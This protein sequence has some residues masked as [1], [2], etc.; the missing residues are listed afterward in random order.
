MHMNFGGKRFN[1]VT[2]YV[3]KLDG[4]RQV[5]HA[6]VLAKKSNSMGNFSGSYS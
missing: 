3:K 4:V 6:K 1:K 2:N 5:G